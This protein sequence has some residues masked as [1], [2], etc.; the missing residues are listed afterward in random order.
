MKFLSFLQELKNACELVKNGNDFLKK[1]LLT[2][3]E[4]EILRLAAQSGE[5]HVLNVDQLTY[6]IVKVGSIALGD[7]NDLASL[8][9]YFDALKRLCSNGYIEYVSGQLFRLS[10]FGLK[11]ASKLANYTKET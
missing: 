8:A 1:H 11:K 7:E 3:T 4:K 10:A 2:E 6:P 9:N 5:I